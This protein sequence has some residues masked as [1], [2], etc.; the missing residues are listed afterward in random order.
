MILNPSTR[1][2]AKEALQRSYQDTDAKLD[3]YRLPDQEDL[4]NI[5][6]RIGHAMFYTEFIQRVEKVTGRRVWFEGSNVTPTVMGAYTTV[7]NQKTYICSFDKIAMPENSIVVTDDRNLPIKEIRGWRTV[8]TRL[9]QSKAMTCSEAKRA[10]DL[11]E[12]QVQDRFT[13]NTKPF[14]T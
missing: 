6:K 10:F 2:S 5:E 9:I 3:Q 12:N 4:K 13:A 14:C 8:I 1:L 7:A 11:I